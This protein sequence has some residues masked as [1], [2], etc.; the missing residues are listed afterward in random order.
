[1]A[2]IT[3]TFPGNECGYGPAKLL[4]DNRGQNHEDE[5]EGGGDG[6]D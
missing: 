2:A 1:M 5:D 3:N 4:T 6:D